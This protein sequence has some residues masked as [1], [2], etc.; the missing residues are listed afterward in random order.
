VGHAVGAGENARLRPIAFG[1]V[2]LGLAV[3]SVFALAFGF[4]GRAIAGW[5]VRDAE[6][7]AVATQLFLVAALFQLADGLQVIGAAVLR[8]IS[9]VK[10]PALITFTA[11]W[12]IALPL[13]Y[14]LGIRGPL[15]PVG[16][17]I[18]IAGGL[19]FDAVFLNLRFARFTRVSPG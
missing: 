19:A 11:Y 17:W 3:M 2:G 6:V 8:A 16:V 12:V 10:M 15:G 9:D 18:G 7:I 13:G 4:G 5:F 1:A 14:V